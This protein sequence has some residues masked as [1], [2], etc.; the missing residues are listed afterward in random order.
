MHKIIYE[1]RLLICMWL[2]YLIIIVAPNYK[3]GIELQKL[4]FNFCMEKI[5]EEKS[6][7]KEE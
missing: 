2:L 3:E 7:I 4:I 6:K 1:L 5:S